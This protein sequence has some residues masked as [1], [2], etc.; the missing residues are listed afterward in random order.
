LDERS[1]EA[2]IALFAGMN[3]ACAGLGERWF[4]EADSSAKKRPQ[5]DVNG[6]AS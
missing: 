5:N 1:Q 3:V 2:Q 4:G 6:A